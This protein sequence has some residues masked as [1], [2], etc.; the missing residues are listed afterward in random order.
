[1]YWLH[2]L[3]YDL[4][5]LSADCTVCTCVSVCL[6][7]R[8]CVCVCEPPGAEA[9]HVSHMLPTSEEDFTHNIEFSDTKFTV[10]KE[11]HGA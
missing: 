3:K 11:L 9:W 5:H 10:K 6:C 7:T 8:V 1:M 4:I 2:F